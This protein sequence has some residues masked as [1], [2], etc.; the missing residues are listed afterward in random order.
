MAAETSQ[1]DWRCVSLFPTVAAVDLQVREAIDATGRP[2]DLDFVD[3][4]LSQA[5]MEARVGGRLIATAPVTPG[6]AAT[7]AGRDGNDRA[8]AVAVGPRPFQ[9]KRDGV[10]GRARGLVVEEDERRILRHRNQVD[11]AVVV[12]IARGQGAAD[13]RDA[14]GGPRFGGDVDQA[15][16]FPADQEQA[17]HVE[18]EIGTIVDHVA[19]RLS[20]VEPAVVVGVEQDDAEAEQSTGWDRPGRS[21]KSGRRTCPCPCS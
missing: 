10:A 16:M 2:A 11:A 4:V 17:R 13:P 9:E 6:A 7:A 20:Q 8:H 15:P 21:P 14:P 18:G 12:E 5:E 3:S 19:V 1:L